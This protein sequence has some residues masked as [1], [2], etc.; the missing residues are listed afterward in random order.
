MRIEIPELALVAL[1]GASSSGK[2]TFAH[3]HFKSTEVLSSDFFRGMVG[4][5]ETDQS[6]TDAAFELLFKAAETRLKLGRFT[7]I[8]ATNLQKA[9]RRKIIELA[10]SQN[11]HTA[12]IVLDTSVKTLLAR[13]A[14]RGDRKLSDGVIR[15]HHEQLRSAIHSLKKEGFRFVFVVSEEDAENVEIVRTKLWTDKRDEY[16]PFDIIGDIHGCHAELTEL[17]DRLGYVYDGGAYS[18][19]EGRKAVFLGDFCDRGPENVKVL[20]TVMAMVKSGNALA[21]PGNHDA[22]LVKYLLGKNVNVIN[23]MERTVAELTAESED[24]RN[25]VRD[26]LDSL[27]SHYVL[28]DGKLVVSH[29]GIKQ[30][31]IGRAS[32]AVREFCIYGD[33]DGSRD[34][35][36]LPVRKDWASDY[37]G[38]ATIVYGHTPVG[39]V[40]NNN[41]TYNIDTGCVFGGSLTALRYP[42]KETV[43]VEAKEVYCE[44]P[45][46]FRTPDNV[47]TLPA[48]Q[49]LLGKLRIETEL[50][51]SINV[52]EENTAAAFE[53][54]SRYSADPR[55]M[56]YLPPTMSPCETSSEPDYLEY[57]TEA[58]GYF[59]KNGVKNVVCEK[60]HMGSRAVVVLCR[61]PETAVKRFG[62]DD[63]SRGI[64]YTRTGRRFF[65]DRSIESAVLDRLDKV[66][67]KTGFWEDFST[68]WVCLDTELMPW[69]EKAQDLIREQYAATG[70]AAVHALSEAERLL[71]QC[72]SNGCGEP[73]EKSVGVE[74][75]ISYYGTRKTDAGRF[76][77]AYGEYCWKVSGVDD[78]RMA[79][80]HILACEGSIFTERT[81]I[82]HM[83]NIDRC[84]TGN[85]SI[86]VETPHIC[87]DTTDEESIAAGVNW[88][89]DIT[90]NG[91]EGMVVKPENYTA[92]NGKKLL[93]PAVKCRGREYL[94]IIYG[95]TYLDSHDLERLKKRSLKRKRDLA[96]K[97]FALGVEA[98]SRFV[99]KEPLYRVNQCV[100]GVL[101]MESEP[102]DPRL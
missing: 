37:R 14:E 93:Q 52:Q 7:V 78:I 21:V 45:R 67:D 84:I 87:V 72:S 2:T 6:V 44:P 12:A 54:M 42:E 22:K 9:P 3:R 36:G 43:S 48:A 29:A 40:R 1:V 31:Y 47:D 35:D 32:V 30:E 83:E 13:N 28:D 27:I 88:W 53:T 102:T 4:D 15:N 65:D 25:E 81:H 49:E 51:P 68:D 71:K 50:I 69:N 66:L 77:R 91:G 90:G 74:E 11:V 46:P 73:G 17:L 94:R 101:A 18:H 86:F 79:P 8:D 82:W 5:D 20:K 63:G 97:E 10:K 33:V 56:I 100:F 92:L 95:M 38:N 60:K 23:G 41:N 57:P 19:P 75:L 96:L 59:R 62:V 58:F 64:I 24:F 55:W 39:E 99:K 85:D 80:F 98:L 26:F 34:D 16:G 70:H 89:K 61:T 76:V